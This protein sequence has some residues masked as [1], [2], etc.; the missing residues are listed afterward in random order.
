LLFKLKFPIFSIFSIISFFTGEGLL[1]IFS[2]SFAKKIEK[3]R[4]KFNKN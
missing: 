1:S 3:I 2:F 4:K